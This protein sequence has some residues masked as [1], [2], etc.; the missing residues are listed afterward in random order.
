MAPEQLRNENVDERADQYSCAVVA[1]ELLTGE[2]PMGMAQPVHLVR[3]EVPLT[4]SQAVAKALSA[5]P[6]QRF[7]TIDEFLAAFQ[8]PS[9]RLQTP[10]Q[11]SSPNVV[12]IMFTD[13]VGS[14][15]MTS[16]LGDL[17]AQEI[18]RAHNQI[19][20]DVLQSFQG[21]EI[22]HT[23]DGIMASFHSASNAVHAALLIRNNIAQLNA[24]PGGLKWNIRIGLN[25]GEPINEGNDLFGATVQLAARTCAAA[26]TGQ[27][28]IT[29][30]VRGLCSGK[31][32]EFTDLGKH[33]LKGIPE[34]VDLFEARS[35]S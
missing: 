29:G 30:V 21:V 35:G 34:P 26:K 28:V 16:A 13:V 20:R 23:G 31:K 12:T 10:G 2:L 6:E 25:S 17:A 7:R 9:F 4:M 14:T 27:V 24:R 8:E 1:Y 32:F 5:K 18:V 22:K 19:V 15:E 33:E 3:P 11:G